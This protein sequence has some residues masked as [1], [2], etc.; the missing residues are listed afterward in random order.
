MKNRFSLLAALALG[1][2]LVAVPAFAAPAKTALD[3]PAMQSAKASRSLLLDIT[4]AGNRLVAIGERGHIVYSDD[5]GAT[6]K[7]ASVPVSVLLT[8]VSFPTSAHGWAVG[9]DGVILA[10]ADGGV[11]WS[12]QHSSRNGAVPGK[13]GAPLLDVWFADAETGFAVGAYGYFLRTS[14]GGKSW[15]DNSRAINNPDGWHLNAI[16]AIPGTSTVFI[17]GEQGKLFRSQ[18][19]GANWSPLPSP[20]DG[21]LFGVAPLGPDLVLVAGLQGRLFASGDAGQSWRQVQTGVTSGINAA[22]RTDDGRVVVVGNAGV[23]L[24]G[25]TRL[26]LVPHARSDRQS[27]TAVVPVSSSSLVVVGEGGAKILPAGGQ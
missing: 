5:N 14:D 4:R 6:W 24:V 26:D 10:S 11:T 17:A 27:I 13:E 15:M 21:S 7:Q 9:H 16:A 8:G 22:A 20:F 19:N 12:L 1:A 23:V 3:R 2:G 18:D 25:D